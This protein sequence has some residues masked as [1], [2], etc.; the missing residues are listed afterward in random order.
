MLVPIPLAG[1]ATAGAVVAAE[2]TV[3]TTVT[4][5]VITTVATT[6]P[7]GGIA[8]LFGATTQVLAPAIVPITTTVMVPASYSVFA[9]F[10]APL[11]LGCVA[12]AGAAY[13]VSKEKWKRIT[14]FDNPS[15][16]GFPIQL[17]GPL[18]IKECSLPRSSPDG[19]SFQFSNSSA[20]ANLLVSLNGF[21]VP[22]DIEAVGASS[23][24]Q[25][26]SGVWPDND[27]FQD[28]GFVMFFSHHH[29]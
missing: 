29:T 6:V 8:G 10:C 23:L 2:T 25:M 21:S 22:S 12:L 16:C 3:A 7:A 26:A 13:V 5:T 14:S 9:A 15:L 17:R 18:T 11:A 1:A 19:Q 20:D 4:S 28:T 27:Q 24:H